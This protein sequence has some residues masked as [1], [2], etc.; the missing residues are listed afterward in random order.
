MRFIAAL[1]VFLFHLY[2][3]FDLEN[4]ISSILV[5][6]AKVGN[7]GVPIF[8]ILSG[9]VIT[10]TASAIPTLKVFLIQR[11]IRLFPM[12]FFASIVIYT[13]NVNSADFSIERF[14][15][16]TSLT[17]TIFGVSP[18]TPVLWT[19]VVEIKFYFV[20][21]L[22]L[23]VLPSIFKGGRRSIV[24]FSLLHLI[25]WIVLR[26]LEADLNSFLNGNIR[27]F[28]IGFIAY[29]LKKEMKK[30]KL[31]AF[32]WSGFLAYYVYC[33]VDLSF[34]NLRTCSL[35]GAICLFLIPKPRSG[36]SH[37]ST[38][39]FV[40][41][42]TSYPLYLLHDSVGFTIFE[43]FLVLGLTKMQCL[44]ISITLTVLASMV[45]HLLLERPTQKLLK[46]YFLK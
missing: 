6:I 4:N 18:L 10:K 27:F 14:L 7:V 13:L 33:S 9:F 42:Q 34:F 1:L 32:Y 3:S 29:Y 45:C 44:V 2:L 5:E 23:F 46:A 36:K 30:D 12:L 43:I 40:L 35:I 19:L 17:Y 28:I 26:L 21:G 41:G 20:M 24:M 15:A 31:L 38:R 39:S 22:I 11:F 25:N 37:R 8:F 16:S